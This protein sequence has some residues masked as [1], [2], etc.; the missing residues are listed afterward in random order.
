MTSPWAPLFAFG[1]AGLL[2]ALRRPENPA[3]WL[4]LVI[5]LGWSFAT[6]PGN[7]SSF[8]YFS[9]LPWV[10]PFG[11]MGTHLLLRLPNGRLPSPRW[12]WV[13]RASTATIAVAGT[14]MPSQDNTPV[15]VASV[16]G[17]VGL[18]A[19]LV[20]IL[21]SVAS[22][23]V[24]RRRADEEERH[25]LRWIA[26][27]A[28]IFIGVYL[29]SFVPGMLGLGN[30]GDLG[31]LVFLA[32]AAIPAG[33]GVAILKYR[34]WDIDVVIRKALVV[35][36]LAAF[37]TAV[38]ALVV[39]GVGALVGATS[40][41]GLSFVAAALV[42]VGFQPVLARARRFADR[43]V[44]GKRATPYE[45]LAE[46][47]ERVGETYADDEV[48][49]RMARVVAEGIGAVARRGVDQCRRPDARRRAVAGGRPRRRAVDRNERDRC[50]TSR[51]PMRRSPSS[52]RASCW[53]RSRS[54][55]AE[56]PHGPGQDR[57]W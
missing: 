17:I 33:I 6:M 9:A 31:G 15:S 3:G 28:A 18:L 12:R 25:Q 50:P 14:F 11:L 47:S 38:Y 32:Y 2:V 39:G 8:P 56:R 41:T 44:Y 45:V 4:M 40:T 49:Q 34:L 5:G 54:R 13:S 10:L 24:R 1:I 46:F 26:T 27:G 43:F 42:A 52:T 53:E 7:E 48:L 30:T 57:G 22:L 55:A 19:L 20:C 21:L 51:A 36:V 23:F 29:L 37:F 16:L 35:A